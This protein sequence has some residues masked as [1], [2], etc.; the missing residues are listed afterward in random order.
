[1]QPTQSTVS[2]AV[3][4]LHVRIAPALLLTPALR[5]VWSLQPVCTSG[6]VL[7]ALMV[8]TYRYVPCCR[9]Q[10]I[11]DEAAELL[12]WQAIS[13]NLSNPAGAG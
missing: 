3:K 8:L 10:K 2:T 9:N 13:V 5:L 12:H 1:M 6:P 4:A 11:K 7:S